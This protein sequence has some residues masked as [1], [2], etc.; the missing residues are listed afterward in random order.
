MVL[1]DDDLFV[2]QV[3]DG[4]VN[5]RLSMVQGDV[6]DFGVVSPVDVLKV[7]CFIVG[8]PVDLCIKR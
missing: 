1:S 5:V 7:D 4:S 2:P 8:I 3:D 6:R